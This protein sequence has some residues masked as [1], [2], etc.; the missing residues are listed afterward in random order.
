MA[1]TCTDVTRQ[2][3][4]TISQVSIRS[5]R[6]VSASISRYDLVT[7]SRPI[8]RTPCRTESVNSW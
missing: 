6:K 1:M 7:T 8:E 4:A 2:I 3:V 5:Q